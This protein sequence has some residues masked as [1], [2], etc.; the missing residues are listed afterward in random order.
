MGVQVCVADGTYDVCTGCPTDM[1][2]AE[3]GNLA[4]LGMPDLSHPDLAMPDLLMGDSSMTDLALATATAT[5]CGSIYDCLGQGKS[6]AT[7]EANSRTASKQKFADFLGCMQ[8]TCG[9]MGTDAGASAPCMQAGDMGVANCDQCFNNVIASCSGPPNCT[10]ATATFFV[11]TNGQPL[12]CL[13]DGTSAAGSQP[14]SDCGSCIEL[15]VACIME[16][17]TDADCAM[18]QHSD[19]SPATCDTTTNQC[20]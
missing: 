6:L 10:V 15:A 1:A 8:N 11:D 9:V 2:V 20:M 19:G 14:A 4:D 16:C 18:L 12:A 7:C 17:Y 5:A 3:M 13:A